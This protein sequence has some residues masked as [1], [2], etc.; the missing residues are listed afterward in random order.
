M[1]FATTDYFQNILSNNAIYAG[2]VSRT[3]QEA[4]R[5]LQQG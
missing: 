4:L 3:F 2:V 1:K 5:N